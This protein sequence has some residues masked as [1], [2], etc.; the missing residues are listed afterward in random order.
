MKGLGQEIGRIIE[1][2]M[3]IKSTDFVLRSIGK[4]W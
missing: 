2:K 1:G 4:G 3:K